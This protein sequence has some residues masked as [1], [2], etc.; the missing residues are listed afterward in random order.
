MAV[1]A[2]NC[3]TMATEVWNAGAKATRSG[4]SIRTARLTRKTATQSRMSSTVGDAWRD[5][6][7]SSSSH[8]GLCMAPNAALHL[9]LETGAT[10]ERTVEA[11]SS[12]PGSAWL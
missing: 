8:D 11:V 3:P 1:A 5:A 2:A 12:C 6:I 7:V 10:Q 4:P 9:P